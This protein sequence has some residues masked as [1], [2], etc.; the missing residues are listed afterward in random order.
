MPSVRSSA[1][2]FARGSFAALTVALA[3]PALAQEA[4]PPATAPTAEESGTLPDATTPAPAPADAAIAPA[5]AAEDTGPVEDIVVTGSRIARSG[6]T[7]PTPVTV[8]GQE[9]LT[10]LGLTNIAD[11]LNQ[12]PS[13]R[14]TTTPGTQLYFGGTNVGAR[15]LDLRGL[16]ATRTLVLVDGRRFVSSSTQ[17]TVD[18]NLIPTSLLERTEVVT[19]GASAAYGSDAV[20]GVVNLIINKRLE[21]IKASANYGLT[22]R[23][24]GQNYLLSLA[25]GT[26]FAGG[27]GHVVVGGEYEDNKGVGDCYT[28]GW[29]AEDWALVSNPNRGTGPGGNGL[30]ATIVAPGAKASTLAPGGVIASGPLAGI[31]FDAN[32]TPIPFEFGS[33]RGSTY[34]VG[35]GNA[36]NPYYQGIMLAAAV[37]RYATFGHVDYEIADGIEIFAEGSYGQV[38]GR[39]V[40]GQ[41]RDFGRAISIENPFIPQSI[42]DQMITAGVSSI[43]V[44]RA[45]NDLGFLQGYS[46]NR[47]LRASTGFKAEIGG[48]WSVDGYYQYGRNKTLSSTSNNR[49]EANWARAVDAV[50]APDGSIVCRS[51]LTDPTNGCVAY[52]IFGENQASQAARNYVSGTSF[53]TRTL[54]QHV[55]ALNVAGD[56]VDLWAGP[57]SIA[58]GVEWR[59]DKVS[60][61]TDPISLGTGWAVASGTRIGGEI[62][63]KEGYIEAVLPL[64]NDLP[65]AKHAEINGAVRRTDYNTSGAVTTWK[66]GAVYEPNDWL[67]LR[68]TRS[69]DIRAPNINELYSPPIQSQLP[70]FD[71]RPGRNNAQNIAQL[72]T[73]GNLDLSPEIADTFT[74]GIVLQPSFGESRLNFS[75]DY[76]SIKIDDAISTVGAQTIVNNCA[77]GTAQ[78]CDF[79]V[80]DASNQITRV[81]IQFLNLNRVETEGV[82]FA[83]NYRLPLSALGADSTGALTFNVMATYVSKLAT[84]DS[85]GVTID[86]AGQTGWFVTAGPGVPDWLVDA[87]INYTNG[88]LSLTAQGKYVPKGSYDAGQVGPEDDGYDPNL[89]NS[90]SRN[91]VEDRAYLNLSA[92]YT[93]PIGENRDVQF[94][95]NVTNVFDQSPPVSVRFNPILFD[96]I[97]RSYRFGVRVNY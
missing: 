2:L 43:P 8:V 66:L 88:P 58:A 96:T 51:T 80:T 18:L 24:D 20:A 52:N 50:R 36:Q 82:E 78:F 16:G 39:N 75:V 45:N 25:G 54:T 49:I 86:R 89:P 55:A 71:S 61:D 69:R 95:T 94:F 79:L 32:G 93:V 70:I 44:G 3:S 30:P 17:G 5:A 42:V 21:G 14:A 11:A 57:L 53:Q 13:F 62:E 28:R 40:Q 56:V 85:S 97:G 91:T 15:T 27:R 6:F 76:Y 23:G 19:G 9:R 38:I 72:F 37:E 63:V 34:M 12:I 74:A 59:K 60:G 81:N 84:T 48:G 47:T 29:C 31:Q 7:A 35:G 4:V 26:S 90:I 68:A 46:R 77:G 33:L 73:G 65:W 83:A 64:A 10:Q 22:D 41:T 92:Q 1:F 87:T 67:R